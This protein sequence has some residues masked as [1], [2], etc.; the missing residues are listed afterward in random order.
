MQVRLHNCRFHDISTNQRKFYE[1]STCQLKISNSQF[2]ILPNFDFTTR[3]FMNF[4]LV[5][6]KF[7]E[8]VEHMLLSDKQDEW[9]VISICFFTTPSIWVSNE[10]VWQVEYSKLCND[11][12]FY[13]LLLLTWCPVCLSVRNKFCDWIFDHFP[14]SDYAEITYYY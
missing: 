6:S 3:N 2:K 7:H 5:N 14:I 12:F 8:I 11:K 4:R 10:R 1:I 9:W 13:K